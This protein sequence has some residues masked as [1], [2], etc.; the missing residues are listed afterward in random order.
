MDGR[1]M[2]LSARRLSR[3]MK[4]DVGIFVGRR[5]RLRLLR[6]GCVSFAAFA[7]IALGSIGDASAQASGGTL[8]IPRQSIDGGA[9]VAS[10]A[11][12]SVR[13]TLGQPDAGATAS[14]P[15][16]AVRGGFHAVA[17][18]TNPDSLFADGFEPGVLPGR[19]V[20]E[21]Q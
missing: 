8:S 18:A 3:V 17:L 12:F 4:H 11:S 5:L 20:S 15:M 6:A 19:P 1:T 13:G 21:S 16:Y 7:A 10:S 9:T 14:G 2:D